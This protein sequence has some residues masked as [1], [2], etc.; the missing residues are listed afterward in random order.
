MPFQNMIYVAGPFRCRSSRWSRP[1]GDALA[2][3]RPGPRSSSP[4]PTGSWSRPDR[5]SGSRLHRGSHTAMWLTRPPHHRPQDRRTAR[6]ALSER[7][8]ASPPRSRRLSE[9]GSLSTWTSSSKLTP[10][11]LA[12]AHRPDRHRC[13][14][15]GALPATKAPAGGCSG[16]RSSSTSRSP[17][18]S[19]CTSST[20]LTQGGFIAYFHPIGMLA[21]IA[22]FHIGLGRATRPAGREWRDRADEPPVPDPGVRRH[23]WQRIM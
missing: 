16:W 21:A 11:P 15:L 2:V 19:S 20:R 22:V 1:T 18:A 6:E 8:A 4:R 12:G 23:P 7:S 9:A 3:Y 5:R 10:N 17:W 14:R 13:H